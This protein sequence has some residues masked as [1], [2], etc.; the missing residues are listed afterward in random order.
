MTVSDL[1]AEA[2]DDRQ[3]HEITPGQ[4]LHRSQELRSGGKFERDTHG[5]WTPAAY[6]GFAIQAMMET[7]PDNAE[8]TRRLSTLRDLLC[9]PF[10]EWLAP[11]PTVSFHQ[12]IAN[13]FSAER[14]TRQ[15]TSQGL[16]AAFPNLVAGFLKDHPIPQT[17]ASVCMHLIG[18]SLFRTAIG[19]LGV[20][21]DSTHYARILNLRTSTYD[22]PKAVK[23]GIV[24]T[25]PFIAHVSLAYVGIDPEPAMR[26]ALAR[27]VIE[28]NREH[29]S[30]P[31][32]FQLRR[33]D[34]CRYDDLTH[35]AFP[36]GYPS[37][38]L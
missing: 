29:F 37:S 20:F 22:H 19:V 24:R 3:R 28:L 4:I 12:T 15:V 10:P 26:S 5:T 11:L 14:L 27:H 21:P 8:T 30:K 38:L 36:A 18:L 33:V 34:L 13:L 23:L 32:P 25:R 9:A 35:F 7:L 17:D 16:L 2:H 1:S 31:V 6:P